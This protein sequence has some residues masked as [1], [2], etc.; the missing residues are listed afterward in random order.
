MTE[1]EYS[2]YCPVCGHCGEIGCCG[3]KTFLEHHVRGKTNCEHEAQII[4]EIEE[5]FDY[6]GKKK[7]E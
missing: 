5:M 3:I 1:E 6:Y 4:D 7:G 2:P